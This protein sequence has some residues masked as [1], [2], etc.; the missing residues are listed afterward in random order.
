MQHY[1]RLLDRPW[2]EGLQLESVSPPS[3]GNY[4]SACQNFIRPRDFP[5]FPLPAA[6]EMKVCNSGYTSREDPPDGL[7]G[8]LIGFET[9]RKKG[10]I[11]YIPDSRVIACLPEAQ[12]VRNFDAASMRIP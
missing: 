9:L 11:L 8:G 2:L 6:A 1:G 3:A 7:A 4:C 12:V 10:A 5:K